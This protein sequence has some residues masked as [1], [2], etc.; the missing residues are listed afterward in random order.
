MAVGVGGIARTLSPIWSKLLV[1]IVVLLYIIW[2][3]MGA[4][5]TSKS[6]LDA[7]DVHCVE[8]QVHHILG[9]L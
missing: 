3:C 6:T 7:S 1:T 4:L 2:G 8:L 5:Y 9:S